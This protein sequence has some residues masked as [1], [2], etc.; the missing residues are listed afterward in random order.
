M[1]LNLEN[2]KGFRLSNGF[3]E[4]LLN[5]AEEC[6][7]SRGSYL[8]QHVWTQSARQST[9]QTTREL[10]RPLRRRQR[11]RPGAL[12]LDQDCDNPRRPGDQGLV[13]SRDRRQGE[14]RQPRH[15]GCLRQP[16]GFSQSGDPR[17]RA[18]QVSYDGFAM[19]DDLVSKIIEAASPS[20]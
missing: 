3:Q 7:V 19:H 5:S 17:A 20:S 4:K 8:D 2:T 12:C 15:G 14:S 10:Y 13:L 1:E 9:P 16:S 6:V 11:S 18:R